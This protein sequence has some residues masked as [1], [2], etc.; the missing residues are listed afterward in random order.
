MRAV[1]SIYIFI[2]LSSRHW[3]KNQDYV[4]WQQK[5][6]KSRK[7]KRDWLTIKT[8]QQDYYFRSLRRH[9]IKND[10]P[11]PFLTWV[12]L[13][14][15]NGVE[16]F[17]LH[18]LIRL[19]PNCFINLCVCVCVCFLFFAYKSETRSLQHLIFSSKV[20]SAESNKRTSLKINR[21][22]CQ[23][24]KFI[25]CPNRDVHKMK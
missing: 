19:R 11:V 18:K 23:K 13:M 1:I 8:N 3:T 25:W 5:L 20:L 21:S 6:T 14:Q 15:R 24:L 4:S 16:K 10:A 2:L 12:H 22:N 17:F 7:R 9:I